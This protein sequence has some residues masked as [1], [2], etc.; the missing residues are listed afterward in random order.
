LC[1]GQIYYNKPK[2]E[3]KGGFSGYRELDTG[4]WSLVTG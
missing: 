1:G 3:I 4:N 2:K